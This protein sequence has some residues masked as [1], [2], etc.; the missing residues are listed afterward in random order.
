MAC[1]RS[2]RG[3]SEHNPKSAAVVEE[4]RGGN[5]GEEKDS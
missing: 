4:G 1:A 2:V 3:R 5:S